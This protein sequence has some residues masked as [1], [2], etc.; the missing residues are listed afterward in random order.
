MGERTDRLHSAY[1]VRVEVVVDSRHRSLREGLGEESVNGRRVFVSLAVVLVFASMLFFAYPARGLSWT[2]TTEADFLAGQRVNLDVRPTGDLVLSQVSTTW[3]RE[4]I[5]LDLGAPGSAD[6]VY[7][8]MP[9]VLKDGAIY[10]M[11]YSG[12][13][14]DRNRILYADSPDGV[15]WTRRGV[16]IDVLQSPWNFDS[17]ALPAVLKEG[18]TYK[19][20]FSGGFWTDPV[21]ADNYYAESADGVT[22][23]ILGVALGRA[24][25]GTWDDTQ[26]TSPNV[27]RDPGGRYWMFYGGWDGTPGGFDIRIGLATST[28]GRTFTRTGVDPILG[29]GPTGSWDDA[30]LV[31]PFVVPG[32]PWRMWYTGTDGTNQRLGLATA[33]GPYNWTKSPGNPD[34]VLGPPSSWDDQSVAAAAILIDGTETYLYYTGGD[35]ADYR[36][37][38][39]RLTPGYAASGSFESQLLDSGSPGSVWRL[40]SANATVNLF[41]LVSVQT[42]TGDTASPDASWSPWSSPVSPGPSPIT[43]PRAR[44]FQVRVEMSTASPVYSPVFTDFTVM[45][46]LNTASIPFPLSPT[47]GAWVNTPG[48]LTQWTYA[49][50][51]GDPQ[52]GM[53]VQ[54]SDRSDFA[55]IAAD[56]GV[57][58]STTS[59]WESPALGDGGWYWRV[60]TLDAYDQWSP[61][62]SPAFARIDGTAPSSSIAFSLSPGYVGGRPQLDSSNRI[63]LSATDSGSGVAQIEY[64]LDGGPVTLYTGPFLP[65]VH[66]PA[67]LRYWAVDAA[68]NTEAA[69]SIDILLDSPPV[70]VPASPAN[71]AWANGSSLTVGWTY[72]DPEGDG[73]S[74]YEV[75]LA[76]N[77]AFM[78]VRSSSGLVASAATAHTFTGV[79]DGAY[80]WRVRAADAFGV[81]SP[82]SSARTI[83][84]DTRAPSVT[85]SFDATLG[86]LGG[87][88]WISAGALVTLT[89]TDS[90]SGIAAIRYA[91]DGVESPY[92]SPFP[93]ALAHGPHVLE[94][95][96]IDLAGNRGATTRVD[97]LLDQTPQATVVS[98][99][100]MAWVNLGPTLRWQPGDADGDTVEAF[101]LQVAS[102]AGFSSIVATSGI[103]SSSGSAAWVPPALADGGYF[104]RV[105]VADAFGAWSAWSA[106]TQFRLDTT[107]PVATA[108]HG[109]SAV[110]PGSLA[111]AGGDAVSVE[112]TDAG[113]GVARLEYSLDGA[114]WTTYSVAIVFTTPGRHVLAFR[115]TD[116]AGNIGET[117]ILLIEVTYPFNWTPVLAVAFC[118]IVAVIGAVAAR[119]RANRNVSTPVAWLLLSGS[120]FVVELVL[121]LYSL[122]T[123]ELATPP[124]ASA[125]LA[126]VLA[127]GAGGLATIILGSK[128]LAGR[129]DRPV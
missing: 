13:D 69:L 81:W 35:G 104:W 91:I 16:V 62:S 80:L 76:D 25:A 57:V 98:P 34:F 4:G 24:A 43:S 47:A 31:A 23:N 122:L 61:F 54:I 106:V 20:W 32:S 33:S 123:G 109:G 5:V 36:I 45:Y 90:G 30:F 50:P 99:I 3:S 67:N 49:D 6:S 10:K 46:D 1:R 18:G 102:D 118:V 114:A 94:F 124:W 7:A 86:T 39:A 78:P 27:Y 71:G 9:S 92:T 128:V 12:Y 103:A 65:S 8:R 82:F 51:E 95:W 93:L 14:G 29:L 97:L 21:T 55:T 96:A 89:A 41:S 88:V 119:R 38:R 126:V 37:G 66:G 15:T 120:S 40:L 125:G 127:V 101:E 70:T 58:L 108:R 75:Q 28:N 113:S 63:L 64:S 116:A 60:R 100:D 83:S 59:S 44:Y 26:V 48:L 52:S 42:R 111:I 129:G 72:S 112:G 73:A 121:G 107:P 115:A 11:W 19:M 117:Q 74:A 22:W 105:R 85:H 68:A 2:Q 84:M 56:S 17:V 77:P 87:R 79:M 110:P 53:E